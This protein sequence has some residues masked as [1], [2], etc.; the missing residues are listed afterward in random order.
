MYIIRNKEI[1]EWINEI[2]YFSINSIIQ[3]KNYSNPNYAKITLKRWVDEKKIY[4][5]KRGIYMSATFYNAHI[6]DSAFL[7]V[8]ASIINPVSYTSAIFELA[9]AGVIPEAIYQI[10]SVTTKRTTEI[11]NKINQF[12]YRSIKQTMFTGFEV[13]QKWGVVYNRAI[14]EKALVDYFY[15]WIRGKSDR[16]INSQINS[17]LRM[18]LEL[19]ENTNSQKK[20]MEFVDL[21]ASKKLAKTLDLLLG[22]SI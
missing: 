16:A 6:L 10:S 20:I 2:P 19:F 1:F 4:R 11:V 14:I 18:N 3:M 21:S 5:L 9:E 13:F 17:G 8:I 12:K 22:Y 7:P 15:Y